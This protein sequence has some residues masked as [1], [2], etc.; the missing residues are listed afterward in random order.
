LHN[1]GIVWGDVN[2]CNV[3][4]DSEQ[5]AWVIDFGGLNNTE[6]VNDDKAE[7]VEGDWQ[8]VGRLIGEF[9]P[10][11]ARGIPWHEPRG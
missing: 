8:S 6:F 7:S 4:I 1:H 5:D 3:V 10:R 9:L 11:R 2:Y